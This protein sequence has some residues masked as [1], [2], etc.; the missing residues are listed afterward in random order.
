[1]DDDEKERL[2]TIE[3]LNTAESL[4]ILQKSQK[5]SDSGKFLKYN[6]YKILIIIEKNDNIDIR[7][8]SVRWLML[9]MACMFMFGNTFCYDNPGPLEKQLEEE[10]NMD[11]FHYSLLY[12]VYSI[13]NMIL[14]ILGGILLDSIGIR[15]G[16][17]LFCSIL[18]IG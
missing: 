12:T 1:M 2:L 10:F 8:S 4:N 9:F 15:T 18:T 13:P 16:L 7:K 5:S 17:I 3:E 14:P 6:R 11:S